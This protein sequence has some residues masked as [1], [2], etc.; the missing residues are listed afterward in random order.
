MATKVRVKRSVING[1]KKAAD[2]LTILDA[3][4]TKGAASAA[5][6]GSPPASAALSGL[7]TSTGKAKTS[8]ALHGSLLLQ[9]RAAGK[10]SQADMTDVEQ[11]AT[12]YMNAVDD[13][14][15]GDAVIIT[16]AGLT[17]RDGTAHVTSAA[18]VTTVN[19]EMGKESCQAVCSWPPAAGAGAYALR[20]NFTPADPTKWQDLPTG[21]SRRRT[22]V[23]P[24]PGAQFLFS[25]AAIGTEGPSAWSDP[26]MVT[27]R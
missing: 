3:V 9:T 15:L 10:V 24:T 27:A 18:K 6:S 17:P 11:K 20:V 21:T 8:L 5:V 26:I 25:V 12:T 1:A 4:L 23:A 16:D 14:A 19:H 7:K 2:R 13:L 22:I